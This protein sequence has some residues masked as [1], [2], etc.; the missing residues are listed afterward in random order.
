MSN[1]FLETPIEYL[2]GV[3]PARAEAL[4]SEA[5]IYT[6]ADLLTFFPFR[7]LDRSKFFRISE[8]TDDTAYIQFKAK[9]TRIQTLG[10]RGTQR[11]IITVKDDS[12]EIDLIW[13]RGL[14]WMEGKFRLDQEFIVFGKPT[15]FNGR[16][17]IPHPDMEIPSDKPLP[18]NETIRPIYSSTEKL[19]SKGLDYK[20]ISKLMKSLLL[21]EKFNVPENLTT[22]ILN[23]FKLME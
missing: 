8:I 12:G 6:F 11:L 4:K 7:Y 22:T 14:K 17:N 13:F 2:K 5:G 1:I 15:M 10:P 19:K 9:I 20:G 18:L 23:N 16:W 3:G 21:N